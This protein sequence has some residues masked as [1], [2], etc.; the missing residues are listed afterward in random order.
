MEPLIPQF[1]TSG[2]VCPGFQNQGGSVTCVLSRLYTIP[3]IQ[4]F[5]FSWRRMIYGEWFFVLWIIF[6]IFIIIFYNIR[7]LCHARKCNSKFC[8]DALVL[9][10]QISRPAVQQEQK[11]CIHRYR[12]GRSRLATD[13]PPSPLAQC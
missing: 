13:G 2:D 7:G 9:T 8:S 1:W 4:R 3:P 6:I 11:C 10:L 12:Q 5:M